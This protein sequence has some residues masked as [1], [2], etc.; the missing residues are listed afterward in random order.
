MNPPEAAQT[1]ASNWVSVMP[2][3]WS[4]RAKLITA[5]SAVAGMTRPQPQT[6]YQLRPRWD[7]PLPPLPIARRRQPQQDPLQPPVPIPRP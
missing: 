5:V 4:R 1:T 7:S 6:T 2:T 3:R